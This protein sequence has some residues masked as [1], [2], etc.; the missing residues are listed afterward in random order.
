M[1]ACCDVRFVP[2]LRKSSKT[3]ISCEPCMPKLTTSSLTLRDVPPFEPGENVTV[4]F[5][6]VW[7]YGRINFPRNNRLQCDD[8]Q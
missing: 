8:Q 6:S 4:T 2:P 5:F 7:P 3:W 1:S